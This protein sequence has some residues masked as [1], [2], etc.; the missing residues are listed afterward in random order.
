M[1]C[2]LACDASVHL[3]TDHCNLLFVFNPAAL[4]PYLGGHKVFKVVRGALFMSTFAYKIE[5]IPGEQNLLADM[6]F[7]L[8]HVYRGQQKALKRIAMIK[9][10]DVVPKSQ[11]ADVKDWPTLRHILNAQKAT[12]E[13]VPVKANRDNDGFIRV[14]SKMWIP[15][16]SDPLKLRI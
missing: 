14:N 15:E 3:F 13:E 10:S 2:M 9:L 5:H 8:M 16:N 12:S 7:R 11:G 6:L 4:E 1:S